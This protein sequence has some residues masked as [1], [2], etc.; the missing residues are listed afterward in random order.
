[1][2]LW[3]MHFIPLSPKIL[4]VAHK[5]LFTRWAALNQK[6]GQIGGVLKLLISRELGWVPEKGFING[7]GTLVFGCGFSCNADISPEK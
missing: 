2:T 1:M 5:R 3:G 6:N 7:S 4:N